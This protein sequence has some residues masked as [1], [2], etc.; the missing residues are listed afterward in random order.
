VGGLEAAAADFANGEG[1][2]H[3]GQAG[4]DDGLARRVLAGAGGEYLAHDDFADGG[5]V[6]ADAGQQGFDDMRAEVGGGNF[7]QRAAKFADGGAAGCYDY[8]IFHVTLR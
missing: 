6:Q 1:R 4:L 8:D 7:G 2:D 3:V 5:A